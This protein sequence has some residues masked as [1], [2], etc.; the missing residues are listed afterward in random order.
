MQNKWHIHYS[1]N[2]IFEYYPNFFSI[3]FGYVESAKHVSHHYTTFLNIIR[4]FSESYSDMLNMQNM[5]HIHYSVIYIF[6]YYPY[7]FGILFVYI[8]NAK[9]VS[10]S[11]FNICKYYPNIF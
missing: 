4:I 7:I 2:Y 3:L 10:Y 6:A 8:E 1:G 9:Q 5:C 11:L